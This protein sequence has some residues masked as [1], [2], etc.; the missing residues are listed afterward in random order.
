M[1][2]HPQTHDPLRVLIAC[3]F[4][5]TVRRAFASRGHDAWSCD[6]LPAEDR[7][8]KHL[9]GDVRNFLGDGWDLLMVAHPPCTRLC[10]SGVRWLSEPPT[11]PPADSTPEQ[12]EAWPHLNREERLAIMWLHLDDGAAL[13]S[14][15]WNAPIPRVAV[16]NPVM[17]PHAKSRIANFQPAAQTVQPWWFGEPAFKATGLYLRGLPNLEPTNKLTPPKPGTP[18]HREWSFIHLATPGPDRWKIRSRFFAGM[19]DAM[20]DQWGRYAMDDRAAA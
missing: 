4:S 1:N 15:C 7:S 6:L 3:E 9:I 14:D 20:A 8:N 10:N 5:G 12:R 13:F 19:A 18:E 17:H 16:E 11:N 2:V